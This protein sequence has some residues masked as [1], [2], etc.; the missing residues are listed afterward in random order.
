MDAPRRPD[1]GVFL[2][3]QQRPQQLCLAQNP[4]VIRPFFD[5]RSFLDFEQD[6]SCCFFYPFDLQ[7]PF[8]QVSFSASVQNRKQQKTRIVVIYVLEKS[9]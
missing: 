5:L 9:A 7:G 6:Q 1:R 2:C 4:A 8:I 3:V